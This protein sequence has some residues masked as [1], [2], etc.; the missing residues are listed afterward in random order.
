MEVRQNEEVDALVQGFR[1]NLHG[2][3]DSQTLE[4]V[5]RQEYIDPFWNA[6]GWDVANRVHASHAEKDVVIEAPVMTLE[7]ERRR[8]RRPDYL[9]RIGGF[10]RFVVE[11]KKPAVDLR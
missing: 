9:F 7:E 5:V 3:H 1:A 10:P 8:S 6:L 11:A 4:A 2:L